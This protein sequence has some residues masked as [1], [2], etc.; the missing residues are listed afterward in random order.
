VTSKCPTDGRLD[1]IQ[2]HLIKNRLILNSAS[3]K[4]HIPTELDSSTILASE[5]SLRIV[6]PIRGEEICRRIGVIRGILTLMLHQRGNRIIF[7][8]PKDF[9]VHAQV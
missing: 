7:L 4:M 5:A 3:Y 8:K 1:G 6:L 9:L 2:V